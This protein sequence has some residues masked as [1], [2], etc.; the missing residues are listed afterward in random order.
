MERWKSAVPIL[1]AL[2]IALTGSLL[3]YKWME[4]QTASAETVQVQAEAVPVCVAAVDLTWGTKIEPSMLKTVPYLKE[5]LPTGY[6]SKPEELKDRVV[7]T[8][9]KA[10]DPVIEH[11]LAP[12]SVTTGGVSAIVSPG[13]RAVAVKGD[14]VIGLAGFISPMNR[15]D[16]MVTIEDPQTKSEVTK[17]VLENI[18]V[19]GTGTQI[20]KNEKGEPAPVDV[21]TLEVDP[22]EAEKLALAST[23]GKLQLSLRNSMDADKILT[24]GATI[25]QTL[26]SLRKPEPEAPKS[27]G[28]PR[29]VPR[30]HTTVEVIR[31]SDLAQ[32]KM[33]L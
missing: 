9:L 3:L 19:L 26:A 14:K 8:P 1:L 22:L 17:T 24:P 12:A 16:V 31:G 30:T 29:W 21:Y 5:S 15:V 25:P 13:K 33:Q 27:A 28:A 10:N 23:N 7:I 18:L 20:Q 6:F 32:Q 4:S 2:V 11:R